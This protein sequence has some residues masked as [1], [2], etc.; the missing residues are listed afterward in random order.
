MA[1]FQG[2]RLVYQRATHYVDA[3]LGRTV[4]FRR[5]NLQCLGA[6]PFRVQHTGIRCRIG[7]A[8]MFVAY[9]LENDE[10]THCADLDD[11]SGAWRFAPTMM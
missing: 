4:G 2:A 3:Y 6:F 8:A 7:A 10:I 9:A 5:Q 1:E 11:F